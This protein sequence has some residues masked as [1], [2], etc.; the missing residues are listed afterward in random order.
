M[1]I[2]PA[3]EYFRNIWRALYSAWEGMSVTLSHLYRRPYTI[4]YPDRVGRPVEEGLPERY[5]GILEAEVRMCTACQACER[6]CPISCFDIEAVKD[7]ETKER[8][9]ARFNIDIGKCMYC[10]LCV[11]ACPSGGLRHTQYFAASNTDVYNLVVEFVDEPVAPYK[12]KKGEEPPRPSPRG[13]ILKNRLRKWDL[14]RDL[15]EAVRQKPVD[16]LLSIDGR[17]RP[18]E[19]L[20]PFPLPTPSTAKA[21]L[22]NPPPHAGEG[23]GGGEVAK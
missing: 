9:I 22:P 13:S 7:P 21:P 17:P 16:V 15:P 3:G 18:P 4:Q 8:K 10:G 14:P 6:N 1:K 5:R 12:P 2:G 20:V 19:E 23:K 11:E